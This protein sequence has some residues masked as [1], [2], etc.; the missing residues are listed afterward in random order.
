MLHLKGFSE[1]YFLESSSPIHEFSDILLLY[2]Y[3]LLFFLF[4]FPFSLSSCRCLFKIDDIFI[5]LSK[6]KSKEKKAFSFFFG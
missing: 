1:H 4:I 3:S 2:I 6:I 5:N